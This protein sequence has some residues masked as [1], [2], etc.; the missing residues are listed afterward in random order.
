MK[1]P[2]STNPPQTEK[3][4][5][6]E[7]SSNEIHQL[8][9]VSFA[10]RDFDHEDLKS[11]LETSRKYNA[12]HEISGLLLYSNRNIIQILEGQK[13]AVRDLFE[14]IRVDSRHQKVTLLS[15]EKATKRDFKEWAM[16]FKRVEAERFNQELPN[17]T[18]I[19]ER[20]N[21]NFEL[22]S[23]LSIKVSFILNRFSQMNRLDDLKS[24]S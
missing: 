22:L 14:K 5:R 19:V 10:V 16:G 13:E 23:G 7:F 17:F 8:V 20:K 4:L 6:R 12:Q 21:L 2:D 3:V 18:D 11:I 1:P 9:Y 24:A 15:F